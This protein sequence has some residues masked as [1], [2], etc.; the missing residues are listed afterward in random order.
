[1]AGLSATLLM[2]PVAATNVQFGGSVGHAFVGNAVTSDHVARFLR[3]LDESDYAYESGLE[4][5][6]DGNRH[7]CEGAIFTLSASH[8]RAIT[9]TL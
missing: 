6:L 1:V 7:Y 8:S 3:Q 5:I 2:A 9:A 4:G